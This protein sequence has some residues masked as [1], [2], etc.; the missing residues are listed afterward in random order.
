MVRVE[1]LLIAAEPTAQHLD[2]WIQRRIEP[3][4]ERPVHQFEQPV[5]LP[6]RRQFGVG[7]EGRV[8][9]IRKPAGDCICPNTASGNAPVARFT[10]SRSTPSRFSSDTAEYRKSRMT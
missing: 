10:P 3:R 4:G 1:P 7:R 5:A 6:V 2:E 8:R 9:V